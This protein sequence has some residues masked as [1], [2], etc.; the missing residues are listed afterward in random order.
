MHNASRGVRLRELWRDESAPTAVEY[1]IL[2][3]GI[4]VAIFASVVT[5]GKAVAGL[6]E[7]VT[8]SWP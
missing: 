5:V 7:K 8:T 4:A 1:A 3:S 6:F 2:A